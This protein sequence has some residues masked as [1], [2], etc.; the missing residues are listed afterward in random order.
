MARATEGVHH[1]RPRAGEPRR[2]RA[3]T[4]LARA[5]P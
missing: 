2:P 5:T 3:G 4:T 1:V